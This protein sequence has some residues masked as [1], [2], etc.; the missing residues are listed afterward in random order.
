M[1]NHHKTDVSTVPK[2]LA[3]VYILSLFKYAC[4]TGFLIQCSLTRNYDLR[5]PVKVCNSSFELALCLP[6]SISC[7]NWVIPLGMFAGS[8]HWVCQVVLQSLHEGSRV[9]KSS[10][11]CARTITGAR[12]F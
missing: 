6:Y 8:A 5:Y 1:P 2:V 11:V 12:C 7:Y 9:W 3:R 4:S 10:Y